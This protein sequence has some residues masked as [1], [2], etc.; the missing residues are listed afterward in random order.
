MDIAKSIK[1]TKIVIT[2]F[3]ILI[4]EIEDGIKFLEGI[5]DRTERQDGQLSMLYHLQKYYSDDKTAEEKAD[6]T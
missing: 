6:E 1:E 5:E 2:R 3:S 4:D